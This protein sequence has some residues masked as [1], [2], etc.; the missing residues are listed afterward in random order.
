MRGRAP[1]W[2]CPQASQLQAR[3]HPGSWERFLPCPGPHPF[4]NL[5]LPQ[6]CRQ[7]PP[8]TH[9]PGPLEGTGT[10]VPEKGRGQP[11]LAGLPPPPQLSAPDRTS[12]QVS[13]RWLGVTI[14]L[15]MM[16]KTFSPLGNRQG[17]RNLL[18]PSWGPS[19]VGAAQ[20]GV[21]SLHRCWGKWGY[22]I[23]GSH[24]PFAH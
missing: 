7:V 9:T 4:E 19:F 3:S 23:S 21:R 2:T 17:L 6:R 18:V 12:A 11:V 1:V 8:H 20:Q 5:F 10:P 13:C 24:P 16:K 14:R 22:K 15:V